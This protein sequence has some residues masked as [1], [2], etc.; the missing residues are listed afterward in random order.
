MKKPLSILLSIILMISIC[1]V[2]LFEFTASAAATSGSCG[3]N[4]T[5]QYN[6]Y[7]DTLT[8]S[9]TGA[10]MNYAT[11]YN[12][13]SDKVTT[14]PWGSYYKTL[15]TV[16]INNGV[17]SIGDYAFYFFN[18]GGLTSITIPDSVTSIGE[19]AFSG[20]F[21][22][23]S[24]TIP[25][26]VTSI[27]QYAFRGCRMLTSITIPDSVKSIGAYAFNGCA[28]LATITIPDSVTSIG[29]Y[30]FDGCIIKNLIIAGGSKTITPTI[31]ISKSTLT[32]ITIPNS[33]TSVGECAFDNCTSIDDVWYQGT[34]SEKNN[35][36]AINDFGNS[37][38]ENARWHYYIEETQ[39]FPLIFAGGSGT[40]DDP[41][42]ISTAEEL[43]NV[44]YYM[45]S[46][47]K[48][49]NDIDLT[50][51]TATGGSCNFMGNGWNPIGSNNIYDAEPFTGEFDG[52]GKKII[53]MRIEGNTMPSG[54]NIIRVGLFAC[55][56]GGV[57]DLVFENA[58]IIWS[59]SSTST[60]TIG[61]VA[62]EII[63][64]GVVNNISVTA[65]IINNGIDNSA[66]GI[67][68]RSFGRVYRCSTAGGISNTYSY[69]SSTVHVTC[70][71]GVV[72]DLQGGVV[73]ECYNTALLKLVNTADGAPGNIGGICGKQ[74][75][76]SHTTDTNPSDIINCYN[77]GNIISNDHWAGGILG[78]ATNQHNITNCYNIGKCFTISGGENN[79][80]YGI[81]C[82]NYSTSNKIYKCY[83]L[84]DTGISSTG[85]TVCTDV[86]MKKQST[87]NNFDFENV[88]TMEGDE[89]Y[90]YPELRCFTL[91]G[92]PIIAGKVAYNSIVTASTEKIENPNDTITYKWLVDGIQV[93]TEDSY[94]LTA[95]QIGKKLQLKMTSTTPTKVG[96]LYSKEIVI[97][98]AEQT[99]VPTIPELQVFDDK[100]FE[101]GT[102]STQEYSIDSVNWQSSGLFK[103]LD[104]NK[105]YTV[106]S[107]IVEN[108]L[109][110]TS[111]SKAV[112]TVTT[113]K[114]SIQA[115]VAPTVL[116]A[117][118]SSVTLNKINGY[119]YSI[120]GSNWQNSNV[121]SGL[122]VLETYSFYQRVAETETDYAS[123][124]SEPA[125]FKV[126]N[127]AGKISAPILK[128][129][130]DNKIVII[131][132]E[133]KEYSI[134]G[135]VWQKN[136]TFDNLQPNTQ[137]SIYARTV[138]ND[139]Y[140]AGY[141]S[142]ALVLTTLKNTIEKPPIP[143]VSN[144]TANAV[145]LLEENGFEYS[146]D[147]I[148]WQK[149]NVFVSLLPNTEY[150]F[151]QR[152]AESDTN[153][154]SES[155]EG[156][157]ITTLKNTVIK[158]SAPTVLDKTFDTVT[159]TAIS[160]YE[161]SKNGTTW[162]KSNVFEGL[163]PNT[164]YTFYQ[165]VSETETS[166][167]S[168]ESIPLSVTTLKRNAYKPNAPILI[169]VTQ[170]TVKLQQ[171]SAYEYS[172]DG[173]TW[174]SSSEFTGLT[175]DT[176]YT[177]YQR[178]AETE[179]NYAGKISE[180]TS[181]KTLAK[182]ECLNT[183]EKPIVVM[184]DYNKITLLARKGYEYRLS[185]GSWQDSPEF[186]GLIW[187]KEYN[188]YQRI[189]ETESH[190]SSLESQVLKVNIDIPFSNESSYYMLLLYI[191]AYGSKLSNGNMQIRMVKNGG[192]LTLE[193]TELGVY[194]NIYTTSSNGNTRIDTGFY[195]TD[196]N[197]YITPV[198]TAKY[199]SN[200]K[201]QF[202]L[203]YN[204][205]FDRSI[206]TMSSMLPI[207]DCEEGSIAYETFNA[208]LQLLCMYM[209]AYF[210]DN[211]STTLGGF[212]F[213]DYPGTNDRARYC[214]TASN[215]HIGN[216]VLKYN[217]AATCESDGYTGDYCCSNCGAI[218]TKG[219]TIPSLGG[220]QYSNSCDN[221]CNRC[222][223]HRDITHAYT[224]ECDDTCDICGAKRI[225]SHVYDNDCDD[226]CNICGSRRI[227]S[228]HDYK[229]TVINPTCEE[230]GYTMH[231]CLIC[232]YNYNS[233]Y[234]DAFAH[235]QT[236]INGA[237]KTTCTQNG[238][239]GD[240]YCQICGKKLTDGEVIPKTGH[241]YVWRIT[242]LATATEN[243]LKEE[244]CSICGEKTGK[245]QEL[246]Y[247]GHITGDINGDNSV[248]N[249]D[250][251]RLFQYL[252]DWDV[253]VNEAALDVNGDGAVNNKD[254]TRLFQYLSDWDVIIY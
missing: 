123:P 192:I 106:Y 158:P 18:Y 171:I 251:T 110:L 38:L 75:Y 188:F 7:T 65:N 218:I 51:A 139:N 79:N 167:A 47:F 104:P 33:T 211:L 177:F 39:A 254:L 53:G 242:K 166:Y 48:L 160:G 191:D 23:S 111:E 194:C 247:T 60:S 182:P 233:D 146:I 74:T 133:N 241:K 50:E 162:Q 36:L 117:T 148:N 159:I 4:L 180:P 15:K 52:N 113:L 109:Y 137:Y 114:R 227:V 80:M 121:F 190:K 214:D 155:S 200:N 37:A 77:A 205:S 5:W 230:R 46:H 215:H 107:R 83:Y 186:V 59:P 206:Y 55:V 126:K 151:Y 66:G 210:Y 213:L 32:S 118:D 81:A 70:V 93:G 216:T 225:V 40:S 129:K 120:D 95:D 62:G 143:I 101:I 238:Y 13:S 132:E 44:R 12:S 135:K 31:V 63:Q 131:T 92:E 144:I 174:Q 196:S 141:Q 102:I 22:L 45:S 165:R 99:A 8:I 201:L 73:E 149:S 108:D 21:G 157:T 204:T 130:T 217:Y 57:H 152:V 64:S 103:N 179:L 19:W 10:M 17:T 96:S 89:N 243:G 224:N 24:I 203:T 67:A 1:P 185:D 156:T 168:E 207:E 98:K 29:S 153:Y 16:V 34:E 236:V 54:I 246:L 58:D 226:S 56:A 172:K 249:K 173:I 235:N 147:G 199:Y 100:S 136:G 105:K 91:R 84:Q 28:R 122:T 94:K 202:T 195:L 125:N 175:S 82:I 27:G 11:T 232:G 86:E 231:Y 169:D 150:T 178:V 43:N 6:T 245:S 9:G 219:K 187:G 164:Q 124:A 223:Y 237:K 3:T 163:M 134:G 239:T 198:M 42:L 181:V 170:T 41:Y 252:S 116:K 112:L 61:C 87:F 193:K 25:D 176:T 244:I 49:I 78:R 72:G 154:V 183:P 2:G 115:P 184:V 240:V 197:R 161:Y 221:Q 85:A 212:G 20:C 127:I 253:E 140:Y 234:V 69:K 142:D 35:N 250:L 14:A 229:V 88:W 76:S 138:E 208:N 222:D 26:S 68:G 228:G 71:G 90:P 97:D 145:T 189:K 220:H 209:N 248:N 128:E 30:A 119:E